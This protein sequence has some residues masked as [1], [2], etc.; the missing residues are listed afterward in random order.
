MNDFVMP[1]IV[2][3]KAA[4]DIYFSKLNRALMEC[5]Y[6]RMQAENSIQRFRSTKCRIAGGR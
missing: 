5:I 2:A 3:K 4:E 1:L 6:R